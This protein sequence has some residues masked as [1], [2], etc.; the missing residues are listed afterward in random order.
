MCNIAQDML[1]W[2]DLKYVLE[3]VRQGGLSG[4][5][6]VLK[7]NHATVSRRIAAA[8]A[9]IGAR[10]F[11]R[12]PGGYAP[13]DAG[14]EAARTAEQMEASSAGLSRAI[15][16][17]DQSLSGTLTITAPQLMVERILSPILLDFRAAHPEIDITVVATNEILNLAQREA[18][19]AF[20][21]GDSPAST[22][23]GVRMTEQKAA[24]YACHDQIARLA[25]TPDLPLDWVK[26]AHWPGL[27]KQ[28]TEVW[29]NRRVT[30][31][32]DDMIAAIGA[33]RAGIGA[34]RMACFLGDSDPT[35]A[36]LPGVALFDYTPI[37]V[38]T[39]P[40]LR[41]VPRVATF[42][43]FAAARIRKMR[44]AFEGRGFEHLGK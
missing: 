34:T 28:I 27:P 30:L 41:S 17:R 44:P 24:V 5:A 43:E 8:E 22:L 11:D 21:F 26:F 1:D 13:T 10:L 35:L 18:D 32:V 7:V 2:N 16:A 6:R 9:A 33:V 15:A 36:R 14:L 4:A 20:R 3:T 25:A 19:V 42:M 29:P 23:V 39:H 31:V 37:W 40:D 12:L 38:L